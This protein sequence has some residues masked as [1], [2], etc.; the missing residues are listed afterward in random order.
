MPTHTFEPTHYHHTLAAHPPVLHIV[1]GD[2]VRTSCVDAAGQDRNLRQVTPRGNPMTGPFYVEGAMPGDT[3]V[4]RLE[5]LRPNRNQAWSGAVLAAN[6]VDPEDVPVLA[7]ARGSERWLDWEVDLAS[8]TAR[9]RSPVSSSRWSP[10][11][12]AL[13]SRPAGARPSPPPLLG[14]TVAI[15]TTAVFGRG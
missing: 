15:W 1:P 13:G 4:V 10:C 8:N 3:L 11:W 14:R 2:T 5:Q 12:A 7:Q 9:L 6:V